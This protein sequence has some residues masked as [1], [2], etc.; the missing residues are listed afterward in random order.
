M[1][2]VSNDIARFEAA[3]IGQSREHVS[4]AMV[5]GTTVGI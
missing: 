4:D 2:I 1:T 3:P 5:W